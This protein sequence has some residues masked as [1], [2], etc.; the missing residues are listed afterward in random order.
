MYKEKFNLQGKVAIIIG[1]TGLIGKV[2]AEGLAEFGCNVVICARNKNKCRMVAKR[3]TKKFGVISLG[4]V[5]DVSQKK[6]IYHLLKMTL[7]HFNKVDI[8]ITCHQNKTAHFFEKFEDFPEKG[9]DDILS[10]NL[11]GTFLCCQIIGKQMISQGFGNII[12]M[13]S[14]YGRIS[15]N[16]EIY[17]GTKMGCPA[18]Y[19]VSKAGIVELTKYLAT[20][21]VDKNI[22]VN[23]ISP[24]GVLNQHEKKFLENFSKKSPM[25]RL[26]NKEEIVNAMI[27][28][29]SDASSYITGHDLIIDGGWTTW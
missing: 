17:K 8:L 26:A 20:Y 22:R 15:P 24:Q 11:K 29:A 9:W 18:V 23:S 27:F 10:V 4:V 16:Q 25:K 3:I 6:D 21:W 2:F 5:A 1:G 28:L 12:N 19:S 14:V 7:R 13:G